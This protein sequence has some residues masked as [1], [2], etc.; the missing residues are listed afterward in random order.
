VWGFHP[1]N[2]SLYHSWYHNAKPNLMANNTLKYKRIDPQL[3]EELRAK[4]N[5]PIIWP[6]ILIVVVL[7]AAA[8]PAVQTYRAKIKA[9]GVH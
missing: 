3:R 2:F 9:R 6:I 4:W 8:L 5:K 7:I 1:K